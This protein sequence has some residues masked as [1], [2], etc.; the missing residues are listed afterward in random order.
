MSSKFLVVDNS[1]LK[2]FIR[3][4]KHTNTK[5]EREKQIKHSLAQ[6]GYSFLDDVESVTPVN[7]DLTVPTRGQL[8]NQWKIENQYLNFVIKRTKNSEFYITLKNS[9]NYA[10]WV[11][12]GHN[13]YNQYGGSYGWVQGQFFLKKT[14][15]RYKNNK[16]EHTIRK[17]MFNWFEKLMRG[18]MIDSK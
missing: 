16:Y 1:Q 13:I 18:G 4:F 5:K 7:K 12:K 2:N 9:I 17:Y 10:S 15:E 6:V 11:E 3:Q 14:E 8:R